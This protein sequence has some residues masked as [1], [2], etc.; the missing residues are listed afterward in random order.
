MY[1]K[2]KHYFNVQVLE[3]NCSS[4]PRTAHH[5][6]LNNAAAAAAADALF[7]NGARSSYFYPLEDK[8]M[9]FT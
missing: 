2:S 1:L 5:L 6:Q 8:T 4:N 3:Y 9:T 7:L